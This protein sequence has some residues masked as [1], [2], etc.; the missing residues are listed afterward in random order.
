MTTRWT[1]TLKRTRNGSVYSE[2]T[3]TLRSLDRHASKQRKL[4]GGKQVRLPEPCYLEALPAELLQ[5]IF[6]ASMNGNLLVASPLIAVKLSGMKA[7]YH[8]AFL[9]A[10]FSHDVDR[11]FD[12]HKLHF[13]IP[14]LELPLSSW[15]IRNMTKAILASRWC[16]WG[17]VKLWLAANL[18]YV[19]GELLK[20][21]QPRRAG[22]AIE[23]FMQGKTDLKNLNGHC[24]WARDNEGRSWHVETTMW[25]V[26]LRRRS[27]VNESRFDDNDHAAPGSYRLL[28]DWQ[29][30]LVIQ[31]QMRIFGVMTIG[32]EKMHNRLPDLPDNTPF[33]RVIEYYIGLNIEGRKPTTSSLDVWEFLENRAVW[34]T[35][36]SQWLRETL[37]I[38]YFFRPDDQPFKVS[39]R[40]YRAAAAA[41]VM[42][43]H[44]IFKRR[45]SFVPALYVLFS[46][47][48]LS[49]P[50]TEPAFLVW[51]AKAYARVSCFRWQLEALRRIIARA[52]TAGKLSTRNENHYRT[53]KV[54]RKFSYEMDVRILRYVETG[55]LETIPDAFAPDFNAPLRWHG[56]RLN[57]FP[58]AVA[59]A[60][61]TGF[62]NADL[63][64]I[65]IFNHHSDD[66]HNPRLSYVDAM[67]GAL[68]FLHGK[69]YTRADY[70]LDNL[71]GS[72]SRYALTTYD[73]YYRSIRHDG[74][75]GLFNR[76]QDDSEEEPANIHYGEDPR[77]NQFDL[78]SDEMAAI[79]WVVSRLDK[80]HPIP[81]LI[82]DTEL[83]EPLRG[84]PE[85]FHGVGEPFF[86]E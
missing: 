31:C 5:Q 47:D 70:Q 52:T 39:P 65:D 15:D 11:Q 37:A 53:I 61:M 38:D 42:L 34:A 24:W 84:P 32:K 68:S 2:T 26:R 7:L 62:P 17:Q 56:E 36:N 85:W 44:R 27:E 82:K 22:A 18:R 23:E 69:R 79:D 80:K 25:D 73:A 40:L 58:A 59:E 43:E 19:V 8:A 1:E 83:A 67:D 3:S 55:S 4:A 66:H 41:D 30:E 21:A 45:G 10:F 51:A 48:P 16:T 14:R 78:P 77:E 81:P 76:S 35:R 6:L 54:E 75:Q 74:Y 28:S 71:A 60:E 9:L 20:V 29:Y 64:D 72:E 12:I 63:R 86:Q 46:I 49:L 33:P 50:R 13:L 57:S